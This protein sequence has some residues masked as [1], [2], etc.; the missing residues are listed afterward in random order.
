MVSSIKFYHA[1]CC[2]LCLALLILLVVSADA[3]KTLDGGL[4]F[5]KIEQMIVSPVGDFATQYLHAHLLNMF[6]DD[7]VLVNKKKT[8][9]YKTL[10]ELLPLQVNV[11]AVASREVRGVFPSCNML[12]VL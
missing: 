9:V 12:A 11:Q 3:Y 10:E 8:D 4:L 1:P 6:S 5:I 7:F 2:G